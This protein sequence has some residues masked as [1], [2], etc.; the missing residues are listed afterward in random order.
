[1]AD[2]LSMRLTFGRDG[3]GVNVLYLWRAI[4]DNQIT[5]QIA[6]MRTVDTSLESYVSFLH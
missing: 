5:E 6:V 4:Q 1:M 3:G 2:K